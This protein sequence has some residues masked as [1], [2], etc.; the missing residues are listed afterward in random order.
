MRKLLL[1]IFIALSALNAQ[2]QYS[3]LK[4]IL[5]IKGSEMII[6]TD[7]SRTYFVTYCKYNHY[8]HNY[9][10]VSQGNNYKYL[11]LMDG[12]DNMFPAPDY[13]YEIKDIQ[14]IGQE[15]YFCGQKWKQT[16]NI[17]YNLDGTMMYETVSKGIIGR[18]DIRDVINSG[19]TY[20]ILEIDT[21]YCLNKIALLSS[22]A[23]ATATLYDETTPCLVELRETDYQNN[24]VDYNYRVIRSSISDEYFMD[25]AALS[26]KFV[27][28]SRYSNPS[29]TNSYKYL[30][31]MRYGNGYNFFTTN[32]G[33]YNYNVQNVL[34]NEGASFIS[35][36]PMRL[37]YTHQNDEVV[38]GYINRKLSNRQG[39]PIFYKISSP[40]QTITKTILNLDNVQYS[41]I[42][43]IQYNR[44]LYAKSQMAVLLE[45]VNGTSVMR[46]PDWVAI[47]TGPY[48]DTILYTS[49]YKLLSLAAFQY[50]SGSFEV[51]SAGYEPNNNNKMIHL[52]TADIHG[53]TPKWSN[54]SCISNKVWSSEPA[55]TPLT[56]SLT[57]ETLTQFY[58]KAHTLF[59]P[60]DFTSHPVLHS[61]SC[62]N[63]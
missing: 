51:R 26:D 29:N 47:N 7:Y 63:Y 30:F 13:G 43:D 53:D 50:T 12:T 24:Y 52:L 5:S 58:F 62:Y 11:D 61:T 60:H 21:T 55:R 48:P 57:E 36:E 2:A 15:C 8:N 18:F 34:A 37:A 17:I 56:S 23:L 39:F 6:R 35:M 16:G 31:G 22:R 33:I 20:E 28:V 10:I 3:E 44:P 14:V 1:L 46:F 54:L 42:K 59:T 4:R 41:S 45:D 27:S 38:V 40:G 25:V 19:G 49:T 32:N 9:F